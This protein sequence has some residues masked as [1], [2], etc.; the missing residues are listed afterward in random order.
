MLDEF[1]IK[2]AAKIQIHR[3]ATCVVHVLSRLHT[4]ALATQITLYF[5]LIA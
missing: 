5:L 4:H 1:F 3:Y 2:T